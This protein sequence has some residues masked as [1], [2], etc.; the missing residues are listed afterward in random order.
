[1]N[2]TSGRWTAISD[3]SREKLLWVPETSRGETAAVI[4]DEPRPFC[5]GAVV[6]HL[7]EAEMQKLGE[8]N[9]RAGFAAPRQ[10][11]W[12]PQTFVAILGRME[13]QYREVLEKW[14]KE[15]RVLFGLGRVC[16]H[17][18][19]HF[20]QIAHL[21]C[22][23]EPTWQPPPPDQPGSWEH[24]ADYITDLLIFGDKATQKASQS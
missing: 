11:D 5:I 13:S 23:Q 18:L 19:Y 20:V 15:R 17:N 1:M 14:P 22:L 3:L 10:S 8:V 24:A 12:D 16:Q 7:C 9:V 4:C 21:R 6:A 2:C